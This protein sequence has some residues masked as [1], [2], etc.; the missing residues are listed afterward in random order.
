MLTVE[1]VNIGSLKH[2]PRN[3][4]THSNKQIER[5]S[6]SLLALGWTAPIVVD[7]TSMIIA[8]HARLLAAQRLRLKQV[9]VIVRS[10]LSTMQKRALMLADNGLATKAGWNKAKLA[11]ELG[12]LAPFLLDINLTLED[13]GFEA[14]EFDGLIADFR[15]DGRE[16]SDGIPKIE[17]VAVSKEGD[18]WRLGR[19]FVLNGDS[20]SKDDVD[21]L[22]EHRKA[23]MVF[24]D[25]PFNLKISTIVGR[26][27]RKHR[28]F[29]E[30][31]GEKTSQEFTEFL[32]KIF[33]LGAAH[34]TPG[35]LHFCCMD[36]YFPTLML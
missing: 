10:G 33:A 29:L 19:H 26:G 5:L 20:G 8:G 31:S 32:A 34:S 36:I 24:A 9:P 23:H 14:A 21:L 7:E 16:P 15:D 1:W 2:N 30:G 35:S 12:D 3:A 28:E 13:I 4:R 22:F 25:A 11:P 17:S 6:N 18:L 27:R